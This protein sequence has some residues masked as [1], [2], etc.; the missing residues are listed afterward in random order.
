MLE[1]TWSPH[2]TASSMA[3]QKAS[4]SDVLRKM[5]PRVSTEG[6]SQC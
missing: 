5:W 1:V 6:T 3:M 2:E 4:V